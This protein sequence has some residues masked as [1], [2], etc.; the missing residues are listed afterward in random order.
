MADFK[1]KGRIFTVDE[2]D[3][4]E[5]MKEFNLSRE[6]AVR[7]YFEDMELIDAGKKT[8][9]TEVNAPKQKRAYTKSDKPRKKA[10]RERKVDEEKGSILAELRSTLEYDG[11][12]ITGVKNEAEL[13]FEMNGNNYTIKL[14]KH[15]PPKENKNGA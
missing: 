1:V 15:R 7:M 11:A 12:N 9:I 13:S 3:I 2:T 10:V 6:D 14:I 4:K 5:N 8:P